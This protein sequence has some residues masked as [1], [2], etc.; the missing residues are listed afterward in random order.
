MGMKI[1]TEK[2]Q[3]YFICIHYSVLQGLFLRG[4]PHYL[5]GKREESSIAS[6]G[7][8]YG[9]GH[10]HEHGK[11]GSREVIYDIDGSGHCIDWQQPRLSNCLYTNTL[12]DAAIM[13]PVQEIAWAE[14]EILRETRPANLRV[15]FVVK[16]V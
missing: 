8:G 10:G 6:H 14:G 3:K 5:C 1:F 11:E 4:G 12:Q 13:K 15:R 2:Q 9:H 7:H 16:I